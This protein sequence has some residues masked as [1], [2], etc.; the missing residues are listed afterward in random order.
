MPGTSFQLNQ[1]A[2]DILWA[3]ITHSVSLVH[4]NLDPFSTMAEH[5]GIAETWEGKERRRGKREERRG[6]MISGYVACAFVF[7]TNFAWFSDNWEP[8]VCEWGNAYQ[9]QCT[10]CNYMSVSKLVWSHTS[11]YYLELLVNIFI[12]LIQM[13]WE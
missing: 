4:S 3:L 5:L 13:L 6:R 10:F 7:V 12:Y 2:T 1:S 9:F 8:L 11:G